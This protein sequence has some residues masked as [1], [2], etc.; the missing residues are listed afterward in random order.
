MSFI[1]DEGMAKR[2]RPIVIGRIVDDRKERRRM[3]AVAAIPFEQ[4]RPVEGD[5]RNYSVPRFSCS[6][7][8]ETKS[9]LKFPF[10]KERLP[11]RWMISK[12]TVGRS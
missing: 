11:L 2:D 7:S 4:M 8:I 10:P 6:R 12:K 1:E 9:A 5:S 3:P